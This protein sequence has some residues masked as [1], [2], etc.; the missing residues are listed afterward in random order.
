MR[1]TVNI[2][3]L[4]LAL[5]LVFVGCEKNYTPDPSVEQFLNTN[6]SG[7]KAYDSLKSAHYTTNITVQNKKGETNGTESTEVFLDITDSKNLVMEMHQKFSGSRIKDDITSVDVILKRVDGKYI[8][9]ATT[10]TSESKNVKTE[11]K[12]ED[13]EKLVETFIY[14]D[15]GAYDEGGLYYGDLFMIRIYKFPPESFYVDEENKL[16]VFDE[17][18]VMEREDTGKVRL[19]QT[20][21][22]NELG[23]LVSEYE[24]YESVDGDIVMIVEMQPEY[25]YITT[26]NLS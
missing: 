14:S 22:I 9:D 17:K 23:L 15:N 11:M 25:A 4:M 16:C 3:V 10:V 2:V 6:I 5:L 26:A 13:A 1:R 8:Y 12:D 24:K 21:K 20:T 7:K 19:Y 18:M